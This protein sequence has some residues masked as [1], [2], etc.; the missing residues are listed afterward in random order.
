MAKVL[1]KESTLTEIAEAIR[2]KD[3]STAKMYPAEMAGKIE[4]IETAPGKAVVNIQNANS[5]RI[6]IIYKT[7]SYSL[8]GGGSKDIEIGVGESITVTVYVVSW[9]TSVSSYDSTY[10]DVTNTNKA[11]VITLKK[12]SDKTLKVKV[13][14]ST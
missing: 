1:V 11:S 2:A 14:Y 12:A 13:N 7:N 5:N 3:G 10:F 8:S 4:A 6:Y 9:E